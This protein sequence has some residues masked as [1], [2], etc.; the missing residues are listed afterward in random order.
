[1]IYNHLRHY[2]N[3]IGLNLLDDEDFTIQYVL[4]TITNLLSS[5]QIPTQPSKKLWIIDINEEELFISQG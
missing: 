4:D 1:M 3:K 2:G 5:H